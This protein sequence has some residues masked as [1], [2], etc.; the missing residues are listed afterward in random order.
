MCFRSTQAARALGV[1]SGGSTGA[2]WD[3]RMYV[4]YL[5]RTKRCVCVNIQTL[6]SI[7]RFVKSVKHLV[8]LFDYR[9]SLF[10]EEYALVC[11]Y[12][13]LKIVWLDNWVYK[14]NCCLL[15]LG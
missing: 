5:V 11:A 12:C 7:K 13:K 4:V 14:R 8:L 3:G 10:S 6:K 1:K 15:T 9:D 2:L